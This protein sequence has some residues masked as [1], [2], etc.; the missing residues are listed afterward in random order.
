MCATAY[1]KKNILNRFK[2][3]TNAVFRNNFVSSL[4]N[5][6]STA[7]ETICTIF[8]LGIGMLFV[9][10]EKTSIGSVISFYFILGYMLQPIKN[11]VEIQ[12]LLQAANIS[13]ERLNDI[14]LSH[15]EDE[16]GTHCPTIETIT[17]ENINYA[18][19]NT[20]FA[21][22]NVNLTIKKGQ[23]IAFIGKSG[24]GK[25][26]LSK[27]LIRSIDPDSGVVSI[28][29]KNTKNI[30]VSE[31]R[32]KI[33]YLDKSSF[34][35]SDTIINNLKL[36]KNIEN[37]EIEYFCKVCGI[38]D[39]LESLP[40]KYDTYISE[41][42][43]NLSN[44]QRQKLSLARALMCRPDVLILDECLDGLD[45]LSIKSI[46]K[47]LTE[48]CTDLTCIFISHE[49]SYVFQCENIYMLS[50]GKLNKYNLQ[51]DTYFANYETILDNIIKF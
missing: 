18:Y 13:L 21:L 33:I 35:F 11:L 40:H 29:N 39:Y 48:Y 7:I 3:F 9:Y 26:T 36:G 43:L 47:Y 5:N 20:P 28:N 24:S 23:K 41:N 37:D 32:K 30:A 44:G 19:I 6:I 10:Y 1:A 12:P 22:N 15:K 38:S 27:L 49:L 8:I 31:L 45:I 25:S 50:D 16:N 14:T 46:L 42:G 34:F 4:L 2:T 51:N 17:F